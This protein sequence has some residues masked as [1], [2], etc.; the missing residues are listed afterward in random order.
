VGE[1][2]KLLIFGANGITNNPAPLDGTKSS[3]C[4]ILFYS[5]VFFAQDDNDVQLL[6]QHP[7]ISGKSNNTAYVY[8]ARLT[9]CQRRGK[10]YTST[11]SLSRQI[12]IM[13]KNAFGEVLR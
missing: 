9:G 12:A 5:E 8:D 1:K 7:F 10:P 13:D 6:V 2:P 11:F 3:A 4:H